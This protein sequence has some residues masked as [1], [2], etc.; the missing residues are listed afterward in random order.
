M[1]KE[2]AKKY[3]IIEACQDQQQ[4]L[5]F[6]VTQNTTEWKTSNILYSN[7]AAKVEN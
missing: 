1:K 3:E 4:F 2:E 5:S 6:L 7:Y